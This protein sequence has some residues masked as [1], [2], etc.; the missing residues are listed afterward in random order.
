M[1]TIGLLDKVLCAVPYS[2]LRIYL[3]VSYAAA[4]WLSL[5]DKEDKCRRIR[6]AR[7]FR[8]KTR[9][10]RPT[11]TPKPQKKYVFAG[12]RALNDIVREAQAGGATF[13]TIDKLSKDWGEKAGLMRFP[14]VGVGSETRGIGDPILSL[15]QHTQSVLVEPPSIATNLV[16]SHAHVRVRYCTMGL[17]AVEAAIHSTRGLQGRDQRLKEW[18]SKAYGLSNAEARALGARLLDGKQV[19]VGIVCVQWLLLDDG[20]SFHLSVCDGVDDRTVKRKR[21]SFDGTPERREDTRAHFCDVR[22][23]YASTGTPLSCFRAVPKL[24]N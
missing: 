20:V 11:A 15:V 3:E 10:N 16:P 13:A 2:E 18:K 1:L 23:R 17:Q 9:L 8:Q 7:M 6:C 5:T 19:R 22:L 12:S 4:R 21:N 14:E 24:L